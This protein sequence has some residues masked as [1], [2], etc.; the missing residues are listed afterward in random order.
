MEIPLFGFGLVH[1]Q[2][3]TSCSLGCSDTVRSHSRFGLNLEE[4]I[5]EDTEPEEPA[6]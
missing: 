1:T 6:D 2:N 5:D 4:W 3:I